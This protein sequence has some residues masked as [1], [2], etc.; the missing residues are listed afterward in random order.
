MANEFLKSKMATG[1]HVCTVKYTVNIERNSEYR[2]ISKDL[3][4]FFKF[5]WNIKIY[6]DFNRFLDEKFP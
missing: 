5:G 2:K 3:R 4:V 1:E 6:V